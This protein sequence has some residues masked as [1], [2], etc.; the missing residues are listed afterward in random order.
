MRRM[1]NPTYN[2]KQDNNSINPLKENDH[3]ILL[4]ALENILLQ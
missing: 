1:T 4:P 3:W 2:K